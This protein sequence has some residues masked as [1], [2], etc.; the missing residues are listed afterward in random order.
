MC[1]CSCTFTTH[2]HLFMNH[3]SNCTCVHVSCS[4]VLFMFLFMFIV[5]VCCSRLVIIFLGRSE[6]S[7]TDVDLSQYTYINAYIIC[8]YI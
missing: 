2:G 6:N 7:P 5:R 8:I 4:C 1:K 3:F